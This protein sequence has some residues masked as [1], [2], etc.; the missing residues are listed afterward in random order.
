MLRVRSSVFVAAVITAVALV[1]IVAPARGA[2]VFDASGTSRVGNPVAFRATLA[3]SGTTLTVELENRS[4]V[5]SV[6]ADDLLTS[7]Y[8]DIVSGTNRPALVL[9]SGSGFVWQVRAN[10]ND[11]E[12]RYIPQTFTQ[13]S[14]SL[15][16]LKAVNNGDAT[17]EFRAMNAATSP[18]LGFGIGTAGNNGLSPNGFTP[19]IV[20]PPGNGMINFGIYKGGDIDPTGVLD[21]KYVVKNKATFWFGGV[22]GFTEAQI[23]TDVTFGLGTAPD[24]TISLPEPGSISWC[25]IGCLVAAWWGRGRGTR[26]SRTRRSGP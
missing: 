8:F 3:I 18:F 23:G 10:A 12:Y 14:G 20:G 15:S 17:W 16:N 22:G 2:V 13:V 24:S 25:G 1:A 11:L 4:P 6:A 26:F 21:Q 19:A 9:T 5:N 7:F